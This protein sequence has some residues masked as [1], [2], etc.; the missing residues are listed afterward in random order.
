MIFLQSPVKELLY[1]ETVGHCR[2]HEPNISIPTY[3]C[4]SILKIISLFVKLKV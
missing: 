1:L 2:P 4:N 3:F